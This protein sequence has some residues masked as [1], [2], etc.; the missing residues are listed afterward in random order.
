VDNI[1][2]FKHLQLRAIGGRSLPGFTTQWWITSVLN[3]ISH[4]RSC[5]CSYSCSQVKFTYMSTQKLHANKHWPHPPVLIAMV[6]PRTHRL[7]GAKVALV[8]WVS[9]CLE[10]RRWTEVQVAVSAT[11]LLLYHTRR[12]QK[13]RSQCSKENRDHRCVPQLL[14]YHVPSPAREA[15]GRDTDMDLRTTYLVCL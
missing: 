9:D 11:A 1:E 8:T 7:T 10:S 6:G 15:S 13:I 4:S 14:G 3:V 12:P 2:Q 5:L